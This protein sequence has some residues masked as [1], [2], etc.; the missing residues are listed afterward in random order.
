MEDSQRCGR[1][2]GRPWLH[3]VAMV[4]YLQA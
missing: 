4:T 3:E 1:H 2:G